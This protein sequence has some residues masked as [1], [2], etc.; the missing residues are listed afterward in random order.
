MEVTFEESRRH[1]GVES[2]RQCS[3]LAI[4]RTTPVLLGLFSIICWL[5]YQLREHM[6]LSARSCAW[7]VKEQATFSDI[8]ALVRRVIWSQKYFNTSASE[9]QAVVI[10]RHQWEELIEQLAMAA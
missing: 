7:Y 9:G 3:D 10:Q 5:G 2:Q 6:T 4:A 8:L 1:L